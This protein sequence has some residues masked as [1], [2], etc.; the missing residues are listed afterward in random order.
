[1]KRI[2]AL[3]AVQCAA[4]GALTAPVVVG[5]SLMITRMV[6]D[7]AAPGAL[8]V[9]VAAGSAAAMVANPLIG[10]CV[11]RTP[12]R[13]GGRR[14]WIIAGVLGGLAGSVAVAFAADPASLLVAWVATQAAYNG[15][16]AGVNSMLSRD[17]APEQRVRAGAV[18]SAAATIGT[19]PG[20]AAAAVFAADTVTM[21]LVVPVLAVVVVT[22]VVL[23]L[24]DPDAPASAADEGVA[25]GWRLVELRTL[26]TGRFLA[27]MAVRFVLSLELTAGLVFALYLFMDR[28][29]LAEHDAVRLVSAATLVGAAGLLTASVTLALLGRRAPRETTL[30]GAA[31]IVLTAAMLGRALA[32]TPV[33]FYVATF[34]A[35][36]GIALGFASSRAIV[37]GLLPPTRAAFGLGVFNV[38]NALGGIVAPLIATALLSAARA[39][40][41]DGYAGMY[42]LLTVPVLACLA[43][44]PVLGRPVA[45]TGSGLEQS[46]LARA[47]D[48][49]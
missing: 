45:P 42:V 27:V 28:W 46:E 31:L 15:C 33:L 23:V 48:R 38:G 21:T 8:G 43:V 29:D 10:W 44:L 7:T 18:F 19:L 39:V 30:L 3:A 9:V 24:R 5:L 20:L 2:Y 6:G 4:L 41:V 32:P 35:G 11:D 34:A 17:L 49:L 13:F 40:G 25:G 12:R 37:Q 16:F 1:M 36:V 14:I 47:G 22:A 26:L